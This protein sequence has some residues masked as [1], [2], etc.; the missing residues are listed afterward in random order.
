MLFE[1]Y[2]FKKY[3]FPEK[4]IPSSLDDIHNSIEKYSN[5]YKLISEKLNNNVSNINDFIKEKYNSN[6]IDV[7]ND[8]INCYEKIQLRE[9]NN[10]IKLLQNLNDSINKIVADVNMKGSVTFQYGKYDNELL[11]FLQLHCFYVDDAR[12]KTLNIY[13]DIEFFNIFC[14]IQHLK[15]VKLHHDH[16]RKN[17]IKRY[18]FLNIINDKTII[19]NLLYKKYDYV[20]KDNQTRI[21]T[22]E[23]LNNNVV[24]INKLRNDQ[25]INDFIIEKIKEYNDNLIKIADNNLKNFNGCSRYKINNDKILYYYDGIITTFNNIIKT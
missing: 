1:I 18:D 21:T 7:N 4:F 16:Y 15:Y 17:I 19:N 5:E 20:F 23:L 10:N 8:K 9:L 24:P 25:E 11:H 13:D 14:K 6:K 12:C 3:G 2:N 22:D